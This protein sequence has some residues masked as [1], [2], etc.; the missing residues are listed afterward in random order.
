MEEGRVIRLGGR[1]QTHVLEE[2]PSNIILSNKG[3]Y[4]GPLGQ[5]GERILFL[6][7][8]GQIPYG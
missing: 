5:G 2:G 6:N 8:K 1:G 3:N 4:E 7:T